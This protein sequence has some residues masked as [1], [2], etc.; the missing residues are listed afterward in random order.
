MF[1][2]ALQVLELLQRLDQLLEVVEPPGG[3]HRA[4]RLRHISV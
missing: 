4:V 2:K 3:I 1:E